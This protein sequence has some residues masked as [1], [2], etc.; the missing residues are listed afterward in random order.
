MKPS[1][2]PLSVF[3]LVLSLTALLPQAQAAEPGCDEK[4]IVDY[5]VK[6]GD[7]LWD[8][9][10]SHLQ[11][12]FRWPTIW[13]DN[14][15]I[16]DPDLIYPGQKIK[17]H[18]LPGAEGQAGGEG[19]QGG[20]GRAEG[21]PFV[22][23]GRTIIKT[24]HAESK[25]LPPDHAAKRLPVYSEGAILS[26]GFVAGD[27]RPV[28]HLKGSPTGGRL[29]F[30]AGDKFYIDASPDMKIGDRYMIVR[31][32]HEVDHPATGKDM[33]DLVRVVGV[34]RL[35][36]QQDGVYLCTVEKSFSEI[37]DT[38]LLVQYYAPVF[39]YGPAP[40]NAEL[41]GKWGYI[42]EVMGS[43][44]LTDLMGTVYLDMGYDQGVRP[45]DVFTIRRSGSYVSLSTKDRYIIP[46]E[47]A[48]PDVEVGRVQV[49]SVQG[50]TATAR[51]VEMKEAV[52]PGYRVYYKD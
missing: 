49:M 40:H 28:L 1:L 8:I 26:A 51:V 11:D 19:A 27:D 41:D 2:M 10:A 43:R 5:T 46:K 21:G 12:P 9:S 4:G 3:A 18:C 17:I 34:L 48:L 52:Y 29:T 44:E 32:E 39:I 36:I 7:T 31:P 16:Q 37:K 24:P 20:A 33:G 13:K 22:Q 15:F 35:D 38:D 6:K 14:T 47:Y 42:I 45:G 25:V 23:P 50:G 30:S